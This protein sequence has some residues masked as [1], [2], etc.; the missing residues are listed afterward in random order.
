MRRSLPARAAVAALTLALTASACSGD[1]GSGD[2]SETPEDVLA[3]AKTTFDETSGVRITLHTDD[4]PEGLEGLIGADGVGTRAPAFEG[5]IKVRYSGFEPDVPV[6]AV[7]DVVYAQLPLSTGW[8]DIDPGE[9][10]APDPAQLMSPEAGFSSLLPATTDL[11]QGEQVRG[12][13]DNRDVLTEYTGTVPGSAVENIIP[14]ASGDFDAAYTV[15]DDG[16]LRE[17]VLTGVFYPDSESMTY[18][19]GF[20]DYGTSQDIT[21]P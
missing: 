1:D 17:V 7:D 5:T 9:F 13:T 2:G 12:G 20:S 8:S 6:V 19:I 3:E 15:S 11:E 14:T 18:T 10:G 4:L 16:E 21:A